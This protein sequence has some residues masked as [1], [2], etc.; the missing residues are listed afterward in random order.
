MVGIFRDFE[1]S[2][3][4][5]ELTKYMKESQELSLENSDLNAAF[6]DALSDCRQ[7]CATKLEELFAQDFQSLVRRIFRLLSLFI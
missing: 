5:L 6:A 1:L 3:I 7:E 2:Y 4:V